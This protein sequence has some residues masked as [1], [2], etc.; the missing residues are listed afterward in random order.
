MA[1]RRHVFNK[2]PADKT[3][4]AGH[5]KF[6]GD[7]INYLRKPTRRR[8]WQLSSLNSLSSIDPILPAG[9]R[10]TRAKFRRGNATSCLKINVTGGGGLRG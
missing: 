1:L 10:G 9:G 5:K 8:A 4:T 7:E 2:V 6:H 3:G